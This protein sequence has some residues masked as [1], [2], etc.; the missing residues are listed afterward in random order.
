L[1][2]KQIL[3]NAATTLVQVIGSAA[4][5]FFLYRF[6]IRA[7]GVQRL[8]IWSLVLATTSVVTLANQ[9]FATSVVKFVAKYAA[10]GR[11]EDLSVLI[12][13][14]IISVGAML[15]V[16]SLAL[17]PGA[18]WILTVVVPPA[19]VNET[20]AILPYA[21]VSL[22]VNVMGGILLAVLTGYELITRKNYILLAGSVL[23][24]FLCFFFVPRH[25]LL[26]LAYAQTAQTGVCF[27]FSWIVLRPTIPQL[28]FFPHRWD[29]AFFREMFAY[30][31]TFQSI[32]VSQALREPVTKALLTKFGGLALTGFYDM[33]SRWVFT[34]REGIV[35]ANLVLVP[36]VSSLKERD[37]RSIS[38]VYRESYRLIFFLAI[39]TFSFL[40]VV[41][42]LVSQIWL[43]H[44][45]PMFVGFVALLGIAW[46]VNVL[47]NP[48]Y[49][50]DLGTGALRW[51]FIGCAATAILNLGLGFL[52]GQYFGGTAVVAASAFS[53]ALGYV[54][55][56]L[57]Y[58]IQNDMPFNQLLP[59]DSVVIVICSLAGA[60]VFLPWL[61]HAPLKSPFSLHL[62]CEVAAAL[63]AMIVVPMWLH[64]MR[65]RLVKWVSSL[66]PA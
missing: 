28:P 20:L 23:Y 14:A 43:G 42:P 10:L 65:K 5:L 16:L 50:V 64:P 29:R 8:G 39:P 13:T 57:S 34:F 49:V 22:W 31:A 1:K 12:Q 4:T 37:P 11:S 15:A 27:A 51:V 24:L 58:H 47:S 53:L 61:S 26:G 9:G 40:I 7:I 19:H 18:I 17:Y 41:S 60:L 56:L 66:L 46:L 30:G 21:F 38:A 59:R 45:E 3:L 44:Y 6:L 25:G 48:A 36:T 63:F 54:V 55:I 62:I 33:A 32:T 52:A 2:R 35:Q